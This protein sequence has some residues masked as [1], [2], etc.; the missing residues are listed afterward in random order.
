MMLMR[1]L[2]PLAGAALFGLLPGLL[3]LLA[4]GASQA[5]EYPSRTIR[6]IVG[7]GPGTGA[8]ISARILAAGMS[9]ALGQQIVVENRGG[10]GGNIAAEQ[11][12]RAAADGYTIF[13]GTAANVISAAIKPQSFD[14]AKDLAPI[15]LVTA[16]PNI[17]VVHPSAGAETVPA[18]IA[19][20]RAKP[21]ELTFGSAGVGTSPHVSGELF[22][23][24]AGVRTVH[25][26]YQGSAQAMT[27]LL[28]GR[29]TMMFSP[30]STVVPHIRAGTIV[31]LAST[32]LKRPAVAPDLPTM[33]EAGLPGFETAV[34][35]GLNAPAGTPPDIIDR[36]A[37]TADASLKS[38]EIADALQAQGLEPAG[39][40][41]QDYARHI[42]R[43]AAKWTAVA[44][45]A[46]LAK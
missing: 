8:D 27:D 18:L 36:L 31:A 28:A 26:P 7:F 16:S 19:L 24:M 44:K 25:V 11:A 10:A 42:A 45:A 6:L 40:T 32:T 46:G 39:G 9:K 12:A 4:P 43:E 14:F 15:I 5:Q 3:L 22:N 20:A 30:A 21:G 33:D 37:H 23:V 34:W 41:S 1:R 38:P 17:L 29:I 2:L 35:F 13:M